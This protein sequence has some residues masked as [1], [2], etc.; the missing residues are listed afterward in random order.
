MALTWLHNQRSD[1][2]PF[3]FPLSPWERGLAG[4]VTPTPSRRRH[5]IVY[6]T[7]REGVYWLRLFPSLTVER[8]TGGEVASLHQ[9][10]RTLSKRKDANAEDIGVSR[11]RRLGA[12][13]PGGVGV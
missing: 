12:E 3:R 9:V 5:I 7:A 10:H 8:G 11:L 6:A 1:Q 4:E 2:Q 13:C